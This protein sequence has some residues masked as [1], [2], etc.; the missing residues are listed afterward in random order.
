MSQTVNKS[1]LSP[2]TNVM[3]VSAGVND[4]GHLTIGGVDSV[5]LAQRFGTPLY[6]LDEATIRQA[7]KAYQEG[8]SIYPQSR[9]LFAGKSFLCTAMVHLVRELGLGL[10]VV[11][12][13]ELYTAEKAGLDPNL[14]Y[15]H[16][17]N[18]SDAEIVS[19]LK[20]PGVKIV[21]DSEAEIAQ[22]AQLARNLGV[23]AKVMLRVTPGVEPETHEYIKT[24]QTGSKFGFPLLSAIGA[25]KSVLDRKDDLELVGIHAHIGSQSQQIEPFLELID[26]FAD[27]LLEIHQKFDLQVEQLDVGG[28]LGI[29]YTSD[30]RPI[31]IF[32]WSAKV[33]ERAKHSIAKRNLRH[34]LLLVEP[35]RSI[36]GSAGVTLYR[37]GYCKANAA[38]SR[39]VSLDGGMADNPRPIT[40]QAKYTPAIANRMNAKPPEAPITLVGRYCE[41]GDIIIKEAFIDAQTGDLV[42]VFGTGAYNYSM[43]S[44]YNRTTRPA[45]VLVANGEADIIIERETNEDLIRQDRVPKRLLGNT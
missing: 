28:G 45:C 7:A 39:Y 27:L 14:I 42:A 10:D 13:G 20:L 29:T 5:E 11:S 41:S 1:Q 18:K 32:D 38:E 30:D 21:A 24:G 40:Y 26:I 23:K 16:G 43:A 3:P 4:K 19:A 35:G 33:A 44:N 12:E 31:P 22:I 37:A 15:M 34:P 25:V 9:V 6:V 36:V 2:N 17:N 8:L